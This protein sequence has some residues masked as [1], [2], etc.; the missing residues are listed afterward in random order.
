MESKQSLHS[1]GG[2]YYVP[3][4]EDKKKIKK[5]KQNNP[6]QTPQRRSL[7]PKYI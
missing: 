5:L 2:M 4:T 6:K 7:C 1:E 3:S